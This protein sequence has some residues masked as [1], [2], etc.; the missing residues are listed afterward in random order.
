[1]D[2]GW[3][4]KDSSYDIVQWRER[5]WNAV[6]D[7]IVGD[8]MNAGIGSEWW[9][10]RWPGLDVNLLFFVDGGK[11]NNGLSSS[12]FV[13]FAIR[14]GM[15]MFIGKGAVVGNDMDSFLAECRSMH[16]ATSSTLRVLSYLGDRS[17]GYRSSDHSYL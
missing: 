13:V 5:K 1:M 3:S 17:L 7:K 9:T 12:A 8:A 6:V 14:R 4:S 11:R 16:L 2:L 15:M 10:E